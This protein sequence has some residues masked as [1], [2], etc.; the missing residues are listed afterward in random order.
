M[1]AKSAPAAA[2]TE[3][4]LKIHKKALV[5]GQT[6]ATAPL[7]AVVYPGI[8]VSGTGHLHFLSVFQFLHLPPQ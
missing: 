2:K 1:T 4:F 5:R 3:T 7:V 6:A 8:R